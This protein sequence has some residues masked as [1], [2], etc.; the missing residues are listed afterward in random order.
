MIT[1][2]DTNVLIDVFAGDARFGP[3]SRDAL[4]RAR[5]EG[6][7]VLSDVVWAETVAAFGEPDAAE[8]AIATLGATFSAP[9][10]EAGTAA[11]TAWRAYRTAGGPRSRVVSDFLV[12]AHALVQAD[13]LLTRDRGFYRRYFSGLTVLDPTA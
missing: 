9:T 1:A 11:A 3:G 12:G 10:R 4:E 7:L 6:A 2:V 8:A 13:R 5:N